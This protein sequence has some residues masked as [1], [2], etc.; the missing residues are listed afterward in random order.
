MLFMNDIMQLR[1]YCAAL[2]TVASKCRVVSDGCSRF[3]T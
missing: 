2:D 3:G 1:K